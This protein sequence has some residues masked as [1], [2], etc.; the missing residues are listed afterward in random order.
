MQSVYQFIQKSI[1][2]LKIL[3]WFIARS[4]RILTAAKCL[5]IKIYQ[6]I[7][8]TTL[9]DRL[10]ANLFKSLPQHVLLWTSLVITKN[11]F[12]NLL[13]YFWNDFIF[14]FFSLNNLHARSLILMISSRAKFMS[15]WWPKKKR[16]TYLF[17]HNTLSIRVYVQSITRI[18]PKQNSVNSKLML[19]FGY[20]RNSRL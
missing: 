12:W 5:S 20:D 17:V 13:F 19:C 15:V 4:R 14:E 10:K 3:T 2:Q 1:T 6:I 18:C 8:L 7:V 9:K 16:K 11:C